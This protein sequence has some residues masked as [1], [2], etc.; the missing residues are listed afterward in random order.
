MAFFG[1]VIKPGRP[2]PL[3]PHP[4]EYN[5]HI[6]QACLS[7]K[8]PKGKRVSVLVHHDGED[9]VIVATLVAGQLDSVCLDLFFSEYV[10]CTLEVCVCAAYI[11]MKVICLN[12]FLH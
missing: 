11:Y 2:N 4:E 12:D 8:V 7:A 10:E 5:L 9:P 6:S 1:C 3:V